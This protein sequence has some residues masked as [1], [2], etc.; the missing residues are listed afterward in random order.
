MRGTFLIMSGLA[1]ALAGCDANEREADNQAATTETVNETETTASAGG[2]PASA[3]GAWP[4][5]ARIVVEDGVTYRI[6]PGGVRVRLGDAD[7]RIEVIEGVRYRVD[8]GGDR[9]R[10]DDNGVAVTVRD[11]GVNA[12]VP[13]GGNTS[14]TVNSN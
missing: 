11:D 9:I 3:P 6:D 4:E 7:S 10:I 1:I 13:V 8:P 2:S 14:I 5:G 12:T